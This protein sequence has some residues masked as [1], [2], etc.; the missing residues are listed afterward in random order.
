MN[1]GADI[2]S[3]NERNWTVSQTHTQKLWTSKRGQQAGKSNRPHAAHFNAGQ[4]GRRNGTAEPNLAESALAGMLGDGR[5]EVP[6]APSFLDVKS[7]AFPIFLGSYIK[8][9]SNA[10]LCVKVLNQVLHKGYYCNVV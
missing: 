5:L 1:Q 6:W 2:A 10:I 7:G 4:E 3:E 8:S 9:V